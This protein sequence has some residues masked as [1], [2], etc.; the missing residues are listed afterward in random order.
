MSNQKVETKEK[1]IR[2]IGNIIIQG[3]F[4][5]NMLQEK[6]YGQSP[7]TIRMSQAMQ[8]WTN[9][10]NPEQGAILIFLYSLLV[11][12][13]ELAKRDNKNNPKFKNNY[14]AEYEKLNPIIDVL[15]KKKYSNYNSD[16]NGTNY[17]QHMRNAIAHGNVEFKA[18]KYITFKDNNNSSNEKCN[19]SIPL[20]EDINLVIRKLRD[21]IEKFINEEYNP[22]VEKLQEEEKNNKNCE[23]YKKEYENLN[24]IIGKLNKE[25]NS[26]LK[27]GF[28]YIEHM[29]KASILIKSD[30]IV[31]KAENP[32]N[33]EEEIS[34]SIS[35]GYDLDFVII[36][37]EKINFGF[38][39]EDF[40][41]N[42]KYLIQFLGRYKSIFF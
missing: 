18:N 20:G 37:L 11:V 12:P 34:L 31:F 5:I 23:Y 32:E 16:L 1:Y 14:E 30:E 26:N 42:I 38:K 19:F 33:K 6:L 10:K 9:G 8:K 13:K 4:S 17:I 40:N 15:A 21:I 24:R 25:D 27:D 3:F 39:G 36:K 2:R 41:S 28:D 7:E 22:A 29:T 35:L